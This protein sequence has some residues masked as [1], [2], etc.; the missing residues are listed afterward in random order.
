MNI[1]NICI[2]LCAFLSFVVSS[3]NDNETLLTIEGEA[4]NVGE[5]LRLYNKNLDLVKDDSQKD[6]NTYLELFINYRLKLKEA[7]R[8]GLD[9]D[10]NY[11]KEFTSYRKQLVK[12]YISENKVTDQLVK[13]A[14]DRLQYDIK[15][16]H[17]LILKNPEQQDTLTA[18]NEL[19]KHRDLLLKEGFEATKNKIHNGS[20]VLVEDLGYF[21][22][23]KMVYDFESVAYKTKPGTV[24]MP[25]KTDFGY[26]VVRVDEK[27]PSRGT[28]TAAH[29]MISL[30]Q[31]DSLVDPETR[32]NAV[33]KKLQQG[34]SFEALAKQF[35]DDKSSSRNGGELRPFKSGQ[36]SSIAF[37]DAV[38]GIKKPGD[39]IGPILTDYGWHIIKLIKIEPIPNYEEAKRNI[40]AQVKRD[41]R[42]K[43][44]NSAMVKELSQRYTINKND[45][46]EDYFINTIKPSYFA[47][48][49][50]LPE[51]FDANTLVLSVNDS[52]YTYGDFI[53]HLKS[54]QR[55]YMRKKVAI[56]DL[57]SKE[58]NLF[59]EN[60]ILKYREDNLEDEDEAFAEVLQ[61]YRDGLLLFDL[62]EKEIWNKAAKDTVGLKSYYA[63]HT[64]NYIWKDR[65]DMIMASTSDN[66]TA[67]KVQ[68]YLKVGKK[69]T[70]IEK[71]LNSDKSQKVIFTKGI[72]ETS[73]DK[74]PQ[75]LVLEEGVS[76]VYVHNEGFHVLQI[77]KVLKSKPKTL[78]ETKGTVINDYQNH[79]EN[80]WI[81][82]LKKRFKVNVNKDVL[83]KLKSKINN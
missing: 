68:N 70:E 60:S 80:Q 21:S 32:I 79:I 41:S 78:E 48:Q 37:E 72:F 43:L 75:T 19:L 44:I 57:V 22:A 24:S 73:N 52:I 25:F 15:A 16:S 55:T 59:I 69:N 77:N 40:Q 71:I 14:Y 26:H 65:I 17:V 9:N 46:T 6:I 47:G 30:N 33:Y 12:N 5:F 36:L 53:Q 50:Q 51:D 82:G 28:A 45:T 74:L 10:A 83:F 29:I 35:S 76:N 8:L 3:Q 27:R 81:D 66:E 2:V 20:S 56:K 58:L 31:K 34:E 7:Q 38:F 49:L 42:S 62:M 54:K 4:I 67:V 18:Y 61:E 13:E 64:S 63:E 11:K 1:R 39:L 23:F